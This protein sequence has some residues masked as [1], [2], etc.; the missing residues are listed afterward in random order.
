MSGKSKEKDNKE[1]KAREYSN[2]DR[3]R[4]LL[5]HFLELRL[6]AIGAVSDYKEVEDIEIHIL[7]NN[8]FI[9][10]DTYIRSITRSKQ[11]TQIILTHIQDAI[12]NWFVR[13]GKSHGGRL[14]R[15]IIKQRYL[16]SHRETFT[17]ISRDENVP[18]HVIVNQHEVAL[19]E[20]SFLIFGA[21]ALEEHLGAVRGSVSE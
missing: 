4:I 15:R 1:K 6:Y 17:E 18:R 8:G 13:C 9:D 2:V 14:R 7:I 19:K 16:D 20:L 3:T 21:D 5:A 11:T 10:P 12:R